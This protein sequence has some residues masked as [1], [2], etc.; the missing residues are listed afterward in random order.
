MRRSA[1]LPLEIPWQ[2]AR[3]SASMCLALFLTVLPISAQPAPSRGSRKPSIILISIDTLRA[4]H[5]SCYSPSAPKTPNIDKIA[6]GG[7]LFSAVNSLSQSIQSTPQLKTL[8]TVA[9]IARPLLMLGHRLSK[10]HSY[11]FEPTNRNGEL[12]LRRKYPLADP[13]RC[14][15]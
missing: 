7:T 3:C 9:A 15:S 6:Q 13:D 2:L 12:G 5:L 10:L 1:K 4:D 8:L 11:R 14:I